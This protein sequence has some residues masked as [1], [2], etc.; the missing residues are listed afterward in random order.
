MDA[1]KPGLRHN[2]ISEEIIEQVER[3]LAK[4]PSLWLNLT[5]AK[6]LENEGQDTKDIVLPNNRSQV[7]HI[8]VDIGGSL[9]KLLYYVR[10][11]SSPS[12]SSSE[13]SDE[14]S[15]RGGRLSFVKFE[16]S[17][18]D[19]C[20]QFMK[21][22]I[23]DH[24]RESRRKPI[25]VMATGGGAYKFY[26]RMSKELDV[27]V[28]RED[29]MECLIV[30]LNYFVSCIPQEVF[31]LNTETYEMAFQETRHDSKYPH[32]LVN[33]GSGVSILKVTGPS[34]FERIGG[35]SLGGGT[36]WG[37]LSLLTQASSFD[38]MLELSKKG[39]NAAVDMLVGDI[40]GKN[41]GY[42]RFG[43]KDSMIASS[44][45]KVFRENKKSDEF[46]PEDIARS[47]LLAVSN[48]IGQIAYLHAQKHNVKNI[49][50]GGSF[51]RNHVQTMHTLTYAIKFW[52]NQTMNAYFLRHEGYLGVFGAF[53][54][55]AI[56]ESNVP[57]PPIS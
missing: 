17:K 22:L 41:V 2:Q 52:S 3:Q 35:S 36:L 47:L 18:I 7:T 51:I 16:T 50:F 42:E 10:D 12:S 37:L 49:Y 56:S 25:T 29:E 1:K 34:Q 21:Q 8:A 24:A 19:E 28:S 31:V 20:L 5:G 14:V 48:N 57:V 26:D 6:I 11:T 46:L 23:Q 27:E 43:M 54:K 44:F 9:A 38:E 13:I 45:G 15:D 32:M 55:Y 30:G 40:Y 33:I 39:D 53:L 4:P